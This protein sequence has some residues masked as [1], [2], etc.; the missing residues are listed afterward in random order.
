[1]PFQW[2]ITV[3]LN[4]SEHPSL[5]PKWSYP[6][7]QLSSLA[8]IKPYKIRRFYANKPSWKMMQIKNNVDLCGLQIFD[9]MVQAFCLHL[10]FFDH[11][12]WRLSGRIRPYIPWLRTI[13]FFHQEPYIESKRDQT[14]KKLLVC[15]N[16]CV[17]RATPYVQFRGEV[18]LWGSPFSCARIVHTNGEFTLGAIC[19]RAHPL[20]LPFNFQ[21]Y[22]VGLR[23][24]TLM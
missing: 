14:W 22:T 20:T 24:L 5:A 12:A 18:L 16:S 2:C 4:D 6:G 17:N 8:L 10:C 11:P 13:H 9:T 1:M 23:G 19:R 21:S 7:K 3:D 15:P